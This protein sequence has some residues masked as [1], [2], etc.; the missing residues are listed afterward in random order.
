M[1]RVLTLSGQPSC[2]WLTSPFTVEELIAVY[3]VNAL[4]DAH[5]LDWEFGYRYL[6]RGN[7]GCW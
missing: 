3:R 5:T 1:R 7:T 6:I 2:R 4:F